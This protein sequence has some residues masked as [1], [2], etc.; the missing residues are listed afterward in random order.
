MKALCKAYPDYARTDKKWVILE[1]NDP[2]GY[3]SGKG[4]K[5]KREVGMASDDLPRRSPDLNVLDYSLWH[6][7]NIKMRVQEKTF[8]T[9]KVEAAE[10]YLARLRHTALTLPA[11]E[12]QKAVMSMH[13]RARQVVRARGDLFLE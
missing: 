6:A 8:G 1:D 10:D 3:K 12:V 4:L 2:A 5:A 7:I 9:R 13:R 11:K